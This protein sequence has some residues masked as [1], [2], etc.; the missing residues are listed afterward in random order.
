MNLMQFLADYGSTTKYFKS[1]SDDYNIEVLDTGIV[2]DL[3]F[4][5][6][7][8][9]VDQ[10]PVIVGI[11]QTKLTNPTF[12]SILQN[13][14]VSPIGEKLFSPDFGIQRIGLS[15]DQID[16]DLISNNIIKEY[17]FKNCDVNKIYFRQSE[18]VV[19]NEVMGL[20]EFILPGLEEI[21]IR[22]T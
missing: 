9:Y 14:G 2:G 22:Y 8:I 20:K 21:L 7:A 5:V 15:T 11:S 17:V 3:F 4:R 1:W 13:A 6:V 10:I 19:A 16:K 12:L 18:F